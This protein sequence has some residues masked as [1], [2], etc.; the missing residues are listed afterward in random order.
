MHPFLCAAMALEVFRERGLL[1]MEEAGDE[2]ILR[3]CPVKEKVDLEASV[4][5]RTLREI[6]QNRR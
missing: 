3:R 6:E 1:D 5:L 4:Y 2:R